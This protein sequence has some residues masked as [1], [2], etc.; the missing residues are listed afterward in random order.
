MV[1]TRAEQ[2]EQS[3]GG[4][5]E[6]AVGR[7]MKTSKVLTSVILYVALTWTSTQMGRHF[8][9]KLRKSLPTVE[10]EAVVA[11]AAAADAKG[12][13]EG[14][15]SAA[16]APAPGVVSSDNGM[17][18]PIGEGPAEVA[19][20]AISALIAESVVEFECTDA[21]AGTQQGVVESLLT[22]NGRERMNARFRNN[23]PTPLRVKIPAV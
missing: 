23:S 13:H 6:D 21:L 22:G 8:F 19:E 10:Q 18:P 11:L 1:V 2:A 12:G 14:T 5:T 3:P 20:N 4:G 7:G 17:L 9:P 15:K 16:S